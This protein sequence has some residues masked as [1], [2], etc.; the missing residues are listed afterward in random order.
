M[1]KRFL[2]SGETLTLK[3][4]GRD[5]EITPYMKYLVAYVDHNLNWK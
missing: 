1:Q 3:L 2:E 4:K 5:I